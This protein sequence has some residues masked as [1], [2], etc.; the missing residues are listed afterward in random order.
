ML[1]NKTKVTIVISTYNRPDVLS[2]AIKSVILQ[3]FSNW[4]ILV[5]GDHCN[6]E[7]EKAVTS[8]NDSRIHYI[9]LPH[10]VGTQSGPN[11]VG[12]AL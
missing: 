1:N 9:N 11:S 6:Q 12:I 4:K 3:T 2:V 7:T 8:F 10:R 5:I